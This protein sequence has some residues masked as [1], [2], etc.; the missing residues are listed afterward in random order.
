MIHW[1]ISTSSSSDLEIR[2]RLSAVQDRQ[3]RAWALPAGVGYEDME[4]H[5]KSMKFG[6]EPEK[7]GA[8]YKSSYVR[9]ATHGVE[10][11]RGLAR[12]GRK[13]TEQLALMNA[14]KAPIVW[15]EPDQAIPPL[16]D[17]E[18]RVPSGTIREAEPSVV[19]DGP[20]AVALE[21]L[22]DAEVEQQELIV[23]GS[24]AQHEESDES[25]LADS[26]EV[27]SVSGHP[28]EP[29]ESQTPEGPTE[30]KASLP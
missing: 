17:I 15:G 11:L 16:D 14:G 22:G 4:E 7:P 6:G 20:L 29:S 5:W 28:E 9:E 2:E 25:I 10:I 30:E 18:G 19:S 21:E 27:D 24:A 23:D 1:K 26:V 8:V 12:A 13:E 3:F